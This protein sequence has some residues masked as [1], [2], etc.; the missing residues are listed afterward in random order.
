MS[1]ANE[2]ESNRLVKLRQG[3]KVK[4]IW[5]P[6]WGVGR[7]VKAL[8][9]RWHIQFQDGKQGCSTGHTF[10]FFLLFNVE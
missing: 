7:C 3:Q 1:A 5:Y 9:T 4:D 6:E 10:S 8:K 2:V